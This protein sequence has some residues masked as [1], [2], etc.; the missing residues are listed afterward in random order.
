MIWRQTWWHDRLTLWRRAHAMPAAERVD[1]YGRW[2]DRGTPE[3]ELVADCAAFL[4]GRLAEEFD[5]RAEDVPVWAWTN[6]L[7]HGT[8]DDLR[9]ELPTAAARRDT[10]DDYWRANRSHLAALLLDLSE[11]YGPLAEVQRIALIPLEL[12]LAAHPDVTGWTARRWVATVEAALGHY[13]Q[14]CWH[15]A[16]R[17]KL[18]GDEQRP[19]GQSH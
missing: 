17:R 10:S 4:A 13:R 12:A 5:A 18:W 1:G 19:G 8:D 6:L 7:A 11:R 3:G 15:S 2:H 14:A 16:A 9:S